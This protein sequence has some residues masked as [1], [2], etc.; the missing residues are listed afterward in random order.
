MALVLLGEFWYVCKKKKKKRK[1]KSGVCIFVLGCVTDQ[2]LLSSNIFGNLWSKSFEIKTRAG[3]VLNIC[4]ILPQC[5]CLKRQRAILVCSSTG[6]FN[7]DRG[8]SLWGITVSSRSGCDSYLGLHRLCAQRMEVFIIFRL[9]QR[10]RDLFF[11]LRWC[12]PLGRRSW[13]TDSPSR[14]TC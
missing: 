5:P 13:W 9:R 11:L 2:P 12:G 4:Y 8:V 10:L 1:S 7:T 3:V 6:N 14:L